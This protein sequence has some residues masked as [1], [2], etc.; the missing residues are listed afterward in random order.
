MG[1]LSDNPV[2]DVEDFLKK[3]AKK[4]D[5]TFA[6]VGA[7]GSALQIVNSLRQGLYSRNVRGHFDDQLKEYDEISILPG[8]EPFHMKLSRLGEFSTA[9][10]FDFVFIFCE[11]ELYRPILREMGS[12]FGVRANIVLPISD[13]IYSPE[14]IIE[15]PRPIGVTLYPN[16]GADLLGP[17]MRAIMQKSKRREIPGGFFAGIDSFSTTMWQPGKGPTVENHWAPPPQEFIDEAAFWHFRN[18]ELYS[19]NHIHL[20][21]TTATFAKLTDMAILHLVRDPRDVITSIYMRT[22][23]PIHNR[24]DERE[25]T[26]LLLQFLNGYTYKTRSYDF[27][28]WPHISKLIQDFIDADKYSHMRSIRFED[29][30]YNALETLRDLLRWLHLTPSPFFEISDSEINDILKSNSFGNITD[31]ARQEGEN[32]D[33]VATI[34]GVETSLRKGISG[35]WKNIFTKEAIDVFKELTGDKIVELGYEKNMDW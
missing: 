31:G 35:D 7:G 3:N 16:A 32:H 11:A 5:F 21:V 2:K 14:V 27:L 28:V 22:H 34:S 15:N 1:T 4:Q 6:V 9:D 18:I 10:F 13:G 12:R 30:K 19:W 29:L 24:L 20:P 8:K 26:D 25:V 23:G 33:W 17:I